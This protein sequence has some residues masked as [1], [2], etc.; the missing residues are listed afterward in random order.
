MNTIL[1]YSHHIITDAADL[2]VRGLHSSSLRHVLLPVLGRR[3]RLGAHTRGRY[4]HDT[5]LR[6]I[7]SSTVREFWLAID[8]AQEGMMR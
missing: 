6:D 3:D 4:R 8:N 5:R 1:P 2:P 7:S